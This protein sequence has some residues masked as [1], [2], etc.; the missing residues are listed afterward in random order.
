MD[1]AMARIAYLK[2]HGASDYAFDWQRAAAQLWKTAR[3]A[4]PGQVA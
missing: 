2:Q 3:C 1:E 4:P